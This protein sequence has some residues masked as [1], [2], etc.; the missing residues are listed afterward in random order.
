MLTV[1]NGSQ[2][3][4]AGFLMSRVH[5]TSEQLAG[6][7]D[8]KMKRV[9]SLILYRTYSEVYVSMTPNVVESLDHWDGSLRRAC[10]F[11]RIAIFAHFFINTPQEKRRSAFGAGAYWDARR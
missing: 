2:P 5:V 4:G 1:V 8:L 3:R 10:K 11:N 6:R 7:D 9:K